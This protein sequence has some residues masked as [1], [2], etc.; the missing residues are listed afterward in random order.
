MHLYVSWKI[1][2]D[3]DNLMSTWVHTYILIPRYL[4]WLRDPFFTVARKKIFFAG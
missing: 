1:F 3:N 2:A 4:Y